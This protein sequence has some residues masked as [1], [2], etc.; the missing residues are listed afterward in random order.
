MGGQRNLR[1]LTAATLFA[2]LIACAAFAQ[3]SS[4]KRVLLVY[5]RDGAL[6]STVEFEQSLAQSLRAALSPNLE[7]YREQ[8][9]ATR[10]PELR[11]HKITELQSQYAERK[12]DVVIFFGNELT[13]V[14]PGVPV[15]QVSNAASDPIEDGFQRSNFVHVLFNVDSRK[16]IDVARRLQPKARKVLLISGA[17][18]SEHVDLMQFR[19]RLNGEPNL[20]IENVDNASV[21]ELLAI[22]SRLPRE[23]IVLPITYGR[24]P[25]GNSYL[26][27]DIV[28]KLAAASTAPVYAASDTYVGGGAVGGYVIS[29]A[30]TGDI[31]AD[32]AVQILRGKAPA[33]VILQAPGSGVYMFDWRQLKR[34]GFSES[35]LPPESIIVNRVPGPWQK[36]KGYILG[37]VLLLLFESIL[38][39]YLLAERRRRRIAQEQLGER[40]RFETLLAEVSSE[41]AHIANGGMES[42]IECCLRSIREF[43]GSSAAS[44]WEPAEAGRVFLRTHF[45]LGDMGAS[46]PDKLSTDD[47]QDTIRRLQQGENV[48]FSNKTEMDELQDGESFRNA[49]LRSFLAIPLQDKERFIGF[50]SL[51]NMAQDMSW[52]PDIVQRLR[53]IAEIVS[54]ALAREHATEALHESEVL[55]GVILDYMQSNIVVIDKDGVILEVNQYWV[56]SAARDGASPRYTIG[57]G[58]NYREVCRTDIGSEEGMQALLGIQSVLRGSRQTFESEYPCH[59]PSEPRWFRMTVMCLPRIN[60]GAMIIHFDITQQKLTELE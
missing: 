45:W 49:G 17:D 47:F 56:D 20:D 30:K 5:Q 1:R 52:A 19:E 34:W 27:R 18:P 29:W 8:L 53:V 22:V 35:D 39:L 4:P 28:V 38:I 32:A 42:A 44:V 16:I 24:D 3:S 41:F 43:F 12:I 26:S 51:R 9:D 36:Y 6:P 7:F 37:A 13:E 14:L 11:R 50:L 54:G 23:T 31:A 40:L 48:L 58:V 15:V 2:V 60:G 55:K 46:R 10:F 25:A 33:E 59:S 57:V 21:P